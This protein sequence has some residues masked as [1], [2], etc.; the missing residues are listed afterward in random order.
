MG[1]NGVVYRWLIHYSEDKA[2]KE[3]R[4]ENYNSIFNP[5]SI[6]SIISVLVKRR[7]PAKIATFFAFCASYT[8]INWSISYNIKQ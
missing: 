6:M 1:L 8:L 5:R 4:N 3:A 7:Q 2:L